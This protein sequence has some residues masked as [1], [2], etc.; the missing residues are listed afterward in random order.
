MENNDNPE[1]SDSVNELR[2]ATDT[3]PNI[4]ILNWPNF[5][6]TNEAITVA[7]D[8]E[9]SRLFNMY[10]CLLLTCNIH[11]TYIHIITLLVTLLKLL[12]LILRYQGY[13]YL[14]GYF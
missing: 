3:E 8:L 10:V 6:E 14:C 7:P 9:T 2:E 1:T 4:D 13:S 12:I 5:D 11:I